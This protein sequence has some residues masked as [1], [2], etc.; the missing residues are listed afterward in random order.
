MF[1]KR[2]TRQEIIKDLGDAIEKFKDSPNESSLKKLKFEMGRAK[3]KMNAEQ[4]KFGYF[5]K[6]AMVSIVD[7][8][9]LAIDAFESN[10][11]YYDNTM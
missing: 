7:K 4:N 11:N 5:K 2:D 8:L 3:F 9:E 1:K 6:S 10:Q